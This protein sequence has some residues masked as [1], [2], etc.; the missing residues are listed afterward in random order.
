[1]PWIEQQRACMSRAQ[2]S[3]LYDEAVWQKPVPDAYNGHWNCELYSVV[4]SVDDATSV[5]VDPKRRWQ[6]DFTADIRWIMYDGGNGGNGYNL[7]I[8]ENVAIVSALQLEA[9][10]PAPVLTTPCQVWSR[11]S[12]PRSYYGVF[13]AD[14]LLYVVSLT[15]DPVTLTFDLWSWTSVVYH[16][17]HAETLYQIWTQ[18]SNPRQSYCDLSV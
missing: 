7:I 6:R 8:L 9:A 15:F 17:S 3:S 16:L 13:A 1:M 18:S 2:R 12:Y 4:H 14:S 11:S 10:P 5:D